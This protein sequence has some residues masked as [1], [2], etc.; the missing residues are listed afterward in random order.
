LNPR[1]LTPLRFHAHTTLRLCAFAPLREIIKRFFATLRLCVKLSKGSLRSAPL[2]EII[3]RSFATLRLSVS[4]LFET[5]FTSSTYIPISII[6]FDFLCKPTI[7]PIS[8]SLS[9]RDGYSE[10]NLLVPASCVS[11]LASCDIS[12]HSSQ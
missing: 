8:V 10:K 12:G 11:L 2:R 5:H 6:S 4:F 1:N 9:R 7:D 3:K